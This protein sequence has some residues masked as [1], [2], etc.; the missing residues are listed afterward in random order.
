MSTRSTAALF[1]AAREDAPS[2]DARDAMWSRISAA[3]TVTTAA[4]GA[5]TLATKSAAPAAA[6]TGVLG[7][8]LV[9]AGGVIGAFGAVLGVVL[10]L[11][12]VSP[13]REGASATSATAVPRRTP[14]VAATGARLAGPSARKLDVATL[15][16]VTEID[17]TATKTSSA[18]VQEQAT[19]DPA[20]DLSME[21]KLVS[22]ARAALVRG[23]ADLALALVKRTHRL[24]TRALEPE[25]LGIES[26]ALRSLGR[27][28]EAA[29]IDL[30]LKR[31]FPDS[32]LAR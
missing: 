21:A 12:V 26:R 25:E 13:D 6:T 11:L 29:A 14:A 22:D 15:E 24:A 5:A 28:D 4:A 30:L 18:G 7:T 19:P 27:V 3:S 1:E 10:T 16:V 23:E 17:R 2:A 32:A 20:S 9:I 8:K 31:R